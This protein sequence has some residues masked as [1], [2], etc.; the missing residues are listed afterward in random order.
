M[1]LSS[2]AAA[3]SQA[4]QQRTVAD[5]QLRVLK[6]ALDLEAA[7]ALQLV[8]AATSGAPSSTADATVGSVIDVYA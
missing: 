8:A 3:A 1:E 4:S 5:V 2:I 6:M 7:G